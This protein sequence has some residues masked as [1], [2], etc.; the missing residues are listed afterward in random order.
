MNMKR[1][2]LHLGWA[3]LVVVAYQAG[4]SRSPDQDAV[5]GKADSSDAD[6]R[7]S[8]RSF[9]S[10][11]GASAR[12]TERNPASRADRSELA[13]LFGT[14]EGLGVDALSLKAFKD[15]NPIVRR[16]AFSRL[17]E[18][19]TPENAAS[20]REQLKELGMDDNEWRDF[21]YAWGAMSGRE[22]F[23]FAMASDEED[24]AITMSG[25]AAANPTA[26][27][28]MLKN[29]PEDLAGQRGEL[30]ASLVAGVADH[31][32]GMATDLA[33]QLAG[34]GYENSEQLIRTVANEALRT[35]SPQEAAAWVSSLE[36]G[37]LKGAAMDRIANSYANADPEQAAQWVSQYADESFAQRAIAEV[38]EEWGERAPEAA[39][40]WLSDLPA[41][42]G[43]KSGFSSVFG[44]WE[45]SNP[46]AASEYLASMPPSPQR[47]AAVSGFA[48]G[49]AWQDPEAALAWAQDISDPSL[50]E[51]SLTQVG[52]AY[53]RRNPDA[54]RA[55]LEQSGLSA[56]AQ[57]AVTSPRRGWR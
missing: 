26:A 7:L 30:A 18:S 50:R 1:V 28:S 8:S 14:A 5:S 15:P 57:Q 35:T 49:Y 32:L 20:M 37:D 2:A 55:W 42:D 11:P 39:L 41:S 31:D 54:A 56:E 23:D 13:K 44:D 53:Y 4:S 45:D 16:L 34:E 25:W 46:V 29:L 19:M 38:G 10:G 22:A 27:L 40:G 33:F 43:Q 47:D 6:S 51:R 48:R 12:L 24:L 52:Q 21:H 3:A 36:D 17:L 9:D